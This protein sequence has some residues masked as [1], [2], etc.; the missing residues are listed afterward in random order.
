MGLFHRVHGGAA[1]ELRFFLEIA[2]VDVSWAGKSTNRHRD[3]T[4]LP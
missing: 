2:G 4:K 1:I 3:D